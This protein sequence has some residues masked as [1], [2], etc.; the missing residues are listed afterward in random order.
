MNTC[1]VCGFKWKPKDSFDIEMD[2]DSS[3]NVKI[4]ILEC[5]KCINEQNEDEELEYLKKLE[6]SLNKENKDGKDK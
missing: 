2:D 3:I 6:E 5:P 4:D 1:K